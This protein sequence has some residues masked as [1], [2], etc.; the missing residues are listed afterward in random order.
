MTIPI[1]DAHLDLS[2]NALSYDRDQTLTIAQIRQ[3]ESVI[4]G[5]SRGNNTV[6][7]PEM[8]KGGVG[9]C[10]ATLLARSRPGTQPVKT[11]ERTDLD[12]ANQSIAHAVALGQLGYYQLLEAQGHI[13]MI[14][15]ARALR[16]LWQEWDREYEIKGGGQ[17][18]Q[19]QGSAG[20]PIGLILSMEGADPIVSPAQAEFWFDK[21]LRAASLAHY[22]QSA[23]A[24]GT[25]GD[26]PLTP[27]GR[28]MLAEFARLGMTLD[29][30]HTAETAFYQALDLFPRPVFASHN[31]CRALVGGD[32]QYSDDQIKRL[33]ERGG[34]IGSVFD[35]WMLLPGYKRG[36]TPPTAVSL[37]TVV[38]HMDHICQL[39]GNAR[40]VAIGSD[41]DG[42]FG[43]EQ[44]P[45][46]LGTIAG[47]QKL[48]PILEARGYSQADIR[49]IFHGNWLRFFSQALPAGGSVE[50]RGKNSPEPVRGDVNPR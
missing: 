4:V 39:A 13:R 6:S 25:G 23:Y 33:I 40:H 19:A 42:G 11:Q 32:R 43:C 48:A 7:L 45:H 8:R 44:S 47:L 16:E 29:L 12:Y 26:G 30:T 38:D 22:G 46:D 15:D 18:P 3:R 41:L 1:I 9:V 27:A 2:W 24:F 36:Q 14:H 34:V 20:P 21:G 37:A 5:P 35:A 10:V 49:L 28:E 17:S 50:G 31:N